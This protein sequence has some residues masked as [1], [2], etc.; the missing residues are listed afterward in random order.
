[1]LYESFIIYLLILLLV[2]CGHRGHRAQRGRLE[3]LNLPAGCQML[4]HRQQLLDGVPQQPS[5]SAI[6]PVRVLKLVRLAEERLQVVAKRHG[7]ALGEDA[8]LLLAIGVFDALAAG[9]RPHLPHHTAGVGGRGLGVEPLPVRTLVVEECLSRRTHVNFAQ[10]F[11]N[12][13]GQRGEDCHAPP[14]RPLLVVRLVAVRVTIPLARLVRA[15]QERI[16]LLH[17]AHV[18]LR[19]HILLAPRAARWL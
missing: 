15:R 12:G 16:H 7:L 13:L 10:H 17:V 19:R 4:L 6:L 1:M 8:P 3:A 14:P 11:R 2:A 18:H 5:V 9:Q